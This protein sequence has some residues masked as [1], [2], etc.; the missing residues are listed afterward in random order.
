HS[1]FKSK[2]LTTQTIHTTLLFDP[3][4]E[5]HAKPRNVNDCSVVEMQCYRQHNWE[6]LIASVCDFKAK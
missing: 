3:I 1:D 4:G 2:R 5:L 6:Q